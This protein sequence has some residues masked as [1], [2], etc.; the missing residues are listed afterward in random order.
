MASCIPTPI[1]TAPFY[2]KLQDYST[3]KPNHADN[4]GKKDVSTMKHIQHNYILLITLRS[5]RPQEFRSLDML[6]IH[7]FINL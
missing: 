2:P 5:W 6:D 4:E 7:L 3:F 1:S